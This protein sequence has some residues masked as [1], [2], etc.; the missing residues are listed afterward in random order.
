MRSRAILLI[1]ITA[2]ALSL[3]QVHAE[4]HEREHYREDVV[5]ADDKEIKIKIDS[6]TGKVASFWDDVS[7]GWVEASLSPVD[8]NRA[9]TDK[10]TAHD[11]QDE[12]NRMKNDTW[13]DRYGR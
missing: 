10:V 8:L 4:N 7:Q 5:E 2:I 12:L 11:M 6:D 1:L 13:D 3:S 9:Y